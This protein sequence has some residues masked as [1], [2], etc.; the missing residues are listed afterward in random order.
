MAEAFCRV[1][2]TA[3]EW[4]GRVVSLVFI[5]LTLLVMI[6]VVSRYFFNR[7]TTWSW[8]VNIQLSAVLI[9]MGGGYTL[10]YKGHVIVDIIV[11]RFPPRARA[12]VDMVTSLLFF[13]GIGVL[14]W[15]AIGEAKISIA[16]GERFTS[17]L[18]PPLGPIRTA[19]AIGVF[20]L[21]IQGIAKFIRD[22]LIATKA[23]RESTS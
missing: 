18:E 20:L 5:P 7:P 14:L 3:N 22:F 21:L 16:T 1:V 6:E 10:L 17:L 9:V 11:G 23:R 8:D 19:V 15:L 2:D 13:L 12:I 4:V